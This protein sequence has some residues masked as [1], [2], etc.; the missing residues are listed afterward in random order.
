MRVAISGA[1][2][3]VGSHL[4][5]RYLADGHSVVGIDDLST[6]RLGNLERALENERFRFVAHDVSRGVESVAAHFA[7]AKPVDL[8]LHFA[9]PASP[10]DYARLPLHTLRVNSVGT[11][12]MLELARKFDADFLFAS[13]S[14]VYGDPLVSPQPESYWGNVN[15]R[16]ERSCYDEAKRYG[17]AIVATYVRMYGLRARVIRIFNTYGPRL[18]P[19]DGRV[20]PNF[21]AAA[22]SGR[23]LTIYGDGSQ[24]RSFCFVDDLVEGIVRLAASRAA[25][26]HVVNVG[27]PNEITIREL[28]EVVA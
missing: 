19:G 14:E 16:G 15:P 23:P 24:T 22:L 8:V 10:A 9:S 20:V 13:T 27:N 25:I 7:D 18:R 11:E 5:D 6:G 12:T 17:E 4:V 2:G 28:S 26:G 3:F 21:I 1:A